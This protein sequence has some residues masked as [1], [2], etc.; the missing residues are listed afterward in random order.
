[1]TLWLRPYGR[2]VC[3]EVS[4][5]T[6]ALFRIVTILGTLCGIGYYLLSLW[7]ARRFLAQHHE[8]DMAFAPPV[9]ILKPLSGADPQAYDNLRSHCLQDYPEFEIIFGVSDRD[10]PAV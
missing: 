7:S 2:A 8:P 9:S 5:M 4:I 3:P 1:M 10:D 6:H